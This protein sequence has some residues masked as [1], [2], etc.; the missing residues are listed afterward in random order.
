MQTT[1]AEPRSFETDPAC[2][3]IMEQV[4]EYAPIL[5]VRSNM[6]STVA[7]MKQWL[8]QAYILGQMSAIDAIQANIVTN[9]PTASTYQGWPDKSG[10]V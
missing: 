6:D 4:M 9:G 3:P 1:K 5:F 8:A 10:I 2:A 7:L